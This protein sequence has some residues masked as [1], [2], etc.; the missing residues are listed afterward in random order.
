M[1][2]VIDAS[3]A[4]AWIAADQRSGYAEAVLAACA[5]DRAVVPALW[6]W[7]IANTLVMLERRGRLT[8]A[9]AVYSSVTR[10]LPL[11]ADGEA[12]ESRSLDEINIAQRHQLSVYDA[13]YLALAKSRGLPLATLDT[14]LARAATAEGV[15]FSG[16]SP[17][18]GPMS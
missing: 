8:D 13:A 16:E 18:A 5:S 7:E 17:R 11:D 14:Q 15:F 4:I 9:A 12:T 10:H 6:R 2:L 3:V 1:I